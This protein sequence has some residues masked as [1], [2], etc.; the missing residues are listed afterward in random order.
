MNWHIILL[1]LIRVY[2][3]FAVVAFCYLFPK[4][5]IK[6]MLNEKPVTNYFKAEVYISSTI[7]VF[8]GAGFFSYSHRGASEIDYLV[9]YFIAFIIPT[10]ISVE[11]GFGK[12]NN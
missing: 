2:V 11:Q 10:L 1:L 5:Y 8:L 9:G 7:V 12:K 3:P 6:D 4:F